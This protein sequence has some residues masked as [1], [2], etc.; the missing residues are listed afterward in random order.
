M[1]IVASE[2]R[3]TL[4][5]EDAAQRDDGDDEQRDIGYRAKGEAAQVLES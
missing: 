5:Q 3:R 1:S 2:S 4:H